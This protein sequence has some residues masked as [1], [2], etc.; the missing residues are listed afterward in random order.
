[1]HTQTELCAKID[2][3]DGYYLL[4]AKD[5]QPSLREDLADFFNAPPCDW[6][7]AQAETW[8]KAH[9]LLEHRRITCSPELNEWFARRW[10]GVAQVFCLQRPTTLLKSGKQ[11]Q[12]VYELSNL[13]LT[14]APPRH[15]L[16]L[17]RAH[18]GVENRL[19]WRR[20]VTLGEDSC[21]T[22]TGAAPGICYRL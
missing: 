6:R 7:R 11:R 17:N 12:H 5:N 18:W 22:R 3:D 8:D 19:H 2:S 21:Q 14:Q 4:V 13:S 15:M 1:M 20:D 9:G 10:A 16:E